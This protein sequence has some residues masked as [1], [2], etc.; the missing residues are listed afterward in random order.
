MLAAKRGRTL[1]Q[2]PQPSHESFTANSLKI[3]LD[4]EVTIQPVR[5]MA[6]TASNPAV[7]IKDAIGD[8]PLFD[9]DKSGMK[10]TLT[11]SKKGKYRTQRLARVGKVSAKVM[12][13]IASIATL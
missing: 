6:G 7:T 12:T 4:D 5:T 11:D 10:F 8:L 1:P 9:W 2:I 13:K 3:S